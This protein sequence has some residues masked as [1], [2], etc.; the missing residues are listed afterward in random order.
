MCDLG[1]TAAVWCGG[2]TDVV[3]VVCTAACA[4]DLE[5]GENDVGADTHLSIKHTCLN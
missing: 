4:D 1:A 5:A 3:D 2:A